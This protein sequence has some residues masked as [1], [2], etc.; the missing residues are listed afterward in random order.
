MKTIHTLAAVAAFAAAPLAAQTPGNSPVTET[1]L[2]EHVAWLA[3]D[4]REGRLPG[5]PG[6]TATA[7]YIA[8]HLAAAGFVGGAADGG[9]YQP[10]PLVEYHNSRGSMS[11]RDARGRAVA[12]GEIAV[13][14]P[15]GRGSAQGAPL[16]FVGHGVD[17]AG[18]VVAEVRGKIAVMLSA[19][20][21]GDN[22]MSASD[23]RAALT[24]AGAAAVVVLPPANFPYEAFA[25]QFLGRS[26]QL[27]ARAG[28]A[29]AE[30]LVSAGGGAALLRAG[31]VDPER[32][33]EM[34]AG[35]GFVS[36]PLSLTADVEAETHVR[37]Y[38]SYNVVGRLPGRVASSGAVMI[39]GHWDHLG[40]CRPEGAEDR[41]CNGAVDNASGIAV[42]IEAA[43][44]IGAGER[45]D[46]DV[47]V[48]ATTAEEQGLLG[49]YHWADNPTVPLERIVVNLNIDTVAIAP[50]G[51]PVAMVG[52]GTVPGL[53]AGVDAVARSLGRTID[54]DEEANAFIRRQDGWALTAKGVAS[55]MAGGSFSDMALLTAFL[56]GPYHEPEDELTDAVPLGGAADDADLHVALAR[57]FGSRA[58]YPQP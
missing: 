11:V 40:Q 50:R 12:L 23:R 51:A 57:H 20:R 36:A 1:E 2:R 24:R 34:A 55:I 3:D 10:V 8:R 32:A 19:P 17:A 41:I 16:V 5:T 56:E 46:R 45:P 42:I 22:P 14:S 49:A 48:I 52:R 33:S 7:H 4:A 26:M 27:A 39:M 29:S 47:I 30:V 6:E 13:R 53:E 9:W 43:E 18:Q 35:D 54:S 28:T 44:R 37:R 21:P 25:R 15:A 31:G 58:I 38:N